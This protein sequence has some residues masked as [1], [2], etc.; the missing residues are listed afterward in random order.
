LIRTHFYEGSAQPVYRVRVEDGRTEKVMTSANFQLSD[1]FQGYVFQG[2]AP[3]GLPIV[4]LLRSNSD[5]YAL[6][7]SGDGPISASR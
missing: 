3:D 4:S 5:V 6:E 1:G 7:L 2:L